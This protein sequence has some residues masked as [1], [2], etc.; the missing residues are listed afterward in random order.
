MG[1]VTIGKKGPKGIKERSGA[2]TSSSSWSSFFEFSFGQDLPTGF[3]KEEK[4]RF[5]L[6]QDLPRTTN[7]QQSET[8]SCDS[9]TKLPAIVIIFYA[10]LY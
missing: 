10:D 6:G 1:Y 5:S 3:T 8:N 4:S 9:R 7:Y 2:S